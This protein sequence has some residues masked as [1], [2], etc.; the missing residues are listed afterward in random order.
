MQPPHTTC[1]GSWSAV[2][3]EAQRRFIRVDDEDKIVDNLYLV[4]TFGFAI[5]CMKAAA[6]KP[7]K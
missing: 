6:I 2:F 7:I 1:S 4:V 5:P 3:E